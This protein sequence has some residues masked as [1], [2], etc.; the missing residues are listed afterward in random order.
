MMQVHVPKFAK[1]GSDF[2]CICKKSL[3]AR[4]SPQTHCCMSLSL[5]M[6]GIRQGPGTMLLGFWK[7]LEIFVTKRVGT[8]CETRIRLLTV[9]VETAQACSVANVVTFDCRMTA[10]FLGILLLTA[11]TN[12]HCVLLACC[13]ML[14]HTVF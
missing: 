9:N 13:R 3:A 7:V 1:I 11:I 5:N 10:R 12:N 6:A 2:I 8:V 4:A 14:L